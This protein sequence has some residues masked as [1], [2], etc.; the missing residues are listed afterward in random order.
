MQV[1]RKNQHDIFDREHKLS[2][3]VN[4]FKCFL[5]TTPLTYLRSIV[6][7]ANREVV[8]KDPFTGKMRQ[9]LM[10][11]SNNYLGLADH[12]HVKMRIKNAIDEYGCGIGGPPLLNGYLKLT[13]EAEERVAALKKQESAMLFS[14]GFLANLGVVGALAQHNDLVFYDELSHASFCDGLKQSKANAVSFPHNNVEALASL[15]NEYTAK[16]KGDIYVCT[17]GVFSMDGNLSKLPAIATLCQQYGAILILDDAHGTGVLGTNGSGT[18][19]FLNC[20]QNIDVTMG[21]FSKAFATCGGF[22]AASK[23]LIEYMRFHARSYVF[24]ASIPPTI[25]A[26]V[27]AGIEVMESE[28]WLQQQLMDNARYAKNK[29]QSFDFAATPE[30]AIVTLNIPARM[31]IR[32]AAFKLHQRNIFVNSVEYPAVPLHRQRFRI[33]FMATHTHEDI[34]RLATALEEVWNDK[35]VYAIQKQ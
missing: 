33:S 19:A 16:I 34:D 23:D 22:L 6:S 15:M 25:T 1:Q 2:E 11:A 4:D 21:T 8:V 5:E 32:Q 13:Q 18:A 29:L 27:L 24:S 7:A 20:S 10:F 17:E 31:D 28:P 26:A 35:Q 14:S 9:M 12:P 30:A 3:R